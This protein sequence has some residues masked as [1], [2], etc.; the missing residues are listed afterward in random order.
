MKNLYIIISII[1]FTNFIKAQT[2]TSFTPVQLENYLSQLSS[3]LSGRSLSTAERTMI[4]NEGY[5]GLEK[6]LTTWINADF[7]VRASRIQI[8]T[9]LGVSGNDATINYELP[10]NLLENLIRQNRPYSEILTADYCVDNAGQRMNCDTGAP[11]S[12]GILT[13]RAYLKQYQG[14]FNLSRANN[15][16]RQFACL[17][18]PMSEV[19]QP[20]L[21]QF[22][23][24]PMFANNFAGGS[25]EFGNGTACY[26]CHGQFGAHAQLFVKFDETGLYKAA[27]TGLQNP[28]LEPGLSFNGLNTSHMILPDSAR[29]E[30]SQMFGKAVINL[31]EAV[32]VMS[33]DEN[34]SDCSIR[35][36]IR[37]FLRVSTGNDSINTGT[38]K[39]ISSTLKTKFADPS[40]KQIVFESLKH[41][42][43]IGSLLAAGE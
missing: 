38:V 24:I 20:R 15:M 18:Y 32:L 33:K 3:M 43:V 25:K 36:V 29:S 13:T 2:S 41:P 9:Q 23:L 4:R 22:A 5:V 17:S 19:L 11:F 16:L 27:A 1:F 8:Q 31:K 39:E 28:A 35:N 6:I 21:P 37:Y 12:A 34:F 30:A 10:A 7:F 26:T 14:R 40:F 42:K